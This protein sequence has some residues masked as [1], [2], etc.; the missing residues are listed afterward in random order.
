MLHRLLKPHAFLRY[1]VFFQLRKGNGTKQVPLFV[2]E[3]H[4]HQHI[5]V[6]LIEQ[7]GRRQKLGSIFLRK[8]HIF[9]HAIIECIGNAHH[10]AQVAVQIPVYLG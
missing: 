6:F 9:N 8:V 1:C 4:G 2:K 5:A 10:A 3:R 7:A